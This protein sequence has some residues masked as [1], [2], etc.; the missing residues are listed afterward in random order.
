VPVSYPSAIAAWTGTRTIAAIYSDGEGRGTIT[1]EE[2]WIIRSQ[3]GASFAGTFQS[4]GSGTCVQSGTLSG[5]LTFAGA[6][7]DLTFSTAVGDNPL[8][9]RSSA[10]ARYSGMMSATGIT[11]Q[12]GDELQC[13]F[14]RSTTTAER[15]ISIAMTRR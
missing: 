12:A 15:T 10:S 11:A 5:T 7:S 3:S 9:T 2:T 1:C 4:S 13:S 14:A 8:C 6:I